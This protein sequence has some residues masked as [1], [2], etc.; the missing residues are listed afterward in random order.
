MK[1][2][3]LHFVVIVFS[4]LFIIGTILYRYIKKK[5][6]GSTKWLNN[7]IKE[8]FVV[9]L[10]IVFGI[11][12]QL[13]FFEKR[14]VYLECRKDTMACSYSFSTYFNKEMRL[15]KTY[16]I[17][18]VGYARAKKYKRFGR[19]VRYYYMVEL[20]EKNNLFDLAP[21]YDDITAA[22]IEATRFNQFL[23]GKDE[24]YVFKREASSDFGII[25]CCI[26][27]TFAF[28]L[29]ITLLWDMFRAALKLHK[30]AKRLQKGKA[31]QKDDII[32]R[33]G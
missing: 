6:K 2:E 3:F 19:S 33:N 18:R 16:D 26:A 30:K 7:T 11:F 31:P 4:V 20:V 23:R 9:F 25:I 8:Y 13:F 17:S 29:A 5:Q 21:E 28:F 22:E 24:A 15:S 14:S 27:I 1:I 10:I 32:Q 12:I